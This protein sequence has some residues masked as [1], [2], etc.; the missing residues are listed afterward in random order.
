M[1]RYRILIFLGF[2]FGLTWLYWLVNYLLIPEDTLDAPA[3]M[4]S[5]FFPAFSVVLTRLL[6]REGFSQ[7]WIKPRCFKQNWKYYVLAWFAP[8][9]LVV[10][11]AGLYFLIF[12]NDFDSTMSHYIEIRKQ[13]TG[14]SAAEIRNT[15]LTQLPLI[16]LVPLLNAGLCFGEEWG[17]RGYL[18]PKMMAKYSLPTTLV[19]SGVIWGLWHAPIIYLGHNYGFDYWG[20]P[21]TGIIAMCSS[22]IVL[23]VFFSY[24]T[25]RTGSVLPAVFAHGAVNGTAAL[26]ILFSSSDGNPFIGPIPTGIIG[27][28]GFIVIAVLAYL[29]LRQ[30]D[31]NGISQFDGVSLG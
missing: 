19:V 25:L 28:M 20:F 21:I 23:G 26:G 10:V 9:L 18:L 12:S 6:T 24:V 8:M 22:T 7:V 13:K 1:A 17:W 15:L 2:T 27:G 3:M 4:P 14:D 31:R 16:P 29:S 30:R 11:G 5:M